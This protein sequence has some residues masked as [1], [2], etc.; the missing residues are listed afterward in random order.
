MVVNKWYISYN[1]LKSPDYITTY[2]YEFLD[3]SIK[4]HSFEELYNIIGAENC[5]K[6][7]QLESSKLEAY[8]YINNIYDI[9]KIKVYDYFIVEKIE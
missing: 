8:F 2:F 7:T 4:R 9:N 1:G 5:I 3:K 6:Y